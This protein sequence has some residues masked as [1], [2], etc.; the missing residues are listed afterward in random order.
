MF[1]FSQTF[2]ALVSY[3]DVQSRIQEPMK[4]PMTGESS[5]ESKV[6]ETTPSKM[7]SESK[8]GARLRIFSGGFFWGSSKLRRLRGTFSETYLEK[9]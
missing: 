9:T 2:F 6:Q 3:V 8:P 4:T 1:W 7:S 5:K